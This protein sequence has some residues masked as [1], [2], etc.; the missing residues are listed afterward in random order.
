MHSHDRPDISRQ[1]PP[2]RRHGQVFGRVESIGVDHEISIV[3]VDLGRL[4]PVLAAEEFGQGFT[5]KGVHGTQ[6][7]P[8]RIR[9]DDERV[10]LSRE[11]R[12]REVVQS[13]R[14]VPE[15]FLLGLVVL[16]IRI[17]ILRGCSAGRYLS[18]S[19]SPS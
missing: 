17:T 3:L 10:G 5:L 2:T 15:R 1:V 14:I 11:V 19:Q 13:L 8:C 18:V 12:G 9:R 16:L 7:E 6:V 4:A